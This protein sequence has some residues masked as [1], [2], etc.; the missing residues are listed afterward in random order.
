MDVIYRPAADKAISRMPPRDRDA[1]K[2]KLIRF[3]ETRVGDV[4]KMAGS[5]QWRLRHGDWRAIL[6]IENNIIVVRVAHRRE[7][8]R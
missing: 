4:V 7:V 2:S 1:L 6:T 8:Y 5:D 3:A